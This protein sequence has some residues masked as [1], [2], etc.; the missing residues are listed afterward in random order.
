[1]REELAHLHE[2]GLVRR[3]RDRLQFMD[4]EGLREYHLAQGRADRTATQR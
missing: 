4:L 1:V 3:E 2:V